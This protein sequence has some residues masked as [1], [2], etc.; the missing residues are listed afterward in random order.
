VWQG[1]VPGAEGFCY[2]LNPYPWNSRITCRIDAMRARPGPPTSKKLILRLPGRHLEKIFHSSLS[3]HLFPLRKR[4][5]LAK[6]GSSAKKKR[7]KKKDFQVRW[8]PSQL[9][10]NLANTTT[11]T[12]IESWQ[13]KTQGGQS[14]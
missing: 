6:M 5:R 14:Y 12:E 9:G 2:K 3:G 4:R 7:E 8:R 10:N 1:S 11:E 13:D